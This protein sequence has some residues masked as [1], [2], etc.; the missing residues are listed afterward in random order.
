[1]LA[2]DRHPVVTPR[3]PLRSRRLLGWGRTA[4]AAVTLAAAFLL[5]R[6]TAAPTGQETAHGEVSA[7]R[8]PAAPVADRR[9]PVSR[10]PRLVVGGAE[11]VPD[12]ATEH[13]ATARHLV[14]VLFARLSAPPGA[15]PE[16]S[17]N[18]IREFLQGMAYG[19]NQTSPGVRAA[20]AEQF[21]ERLCTGTL[22]DAQVITLAYLG[23]E[24]PDVTTA[25]G[26]DCAFAARGQREDAPLWYM[27]DAWR[28]SGQEKS[29]TLA[30]I[31]RS[32]T[33]ERTQRRFLSPADQA[34]LRSQTLR[35]Q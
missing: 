25:R 30:R 7:P 20:L 22:G 1:M 8:P 14:D 9:R 12:P 31:E 16:Q 19:V 3:S 23:A 32:A 34:A 21:T 35:T 24:L 33:D 15:V 18:S 17:A 26:F 11:P 4:L 28:R 27:L 10:P 5:G 29:P 13:R 6:G 2:R